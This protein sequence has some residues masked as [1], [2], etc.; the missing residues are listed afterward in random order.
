MLIGLKTSIC[1]YQDD[2]GISVR[3][4]ASRHIVRV[5]KP[6]RVCPVPGCAYATA[7]SAIVASIELVQIVVD[8]SIS[9]PPIL[10]LNAWPI[11]GMSERSG[12]AKFFW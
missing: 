11:G 10:R 1:L 2:N 12:Y 5:R 6:R 8:K 3:I 9:I 7:T 4:G